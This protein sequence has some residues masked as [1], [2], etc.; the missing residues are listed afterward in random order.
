MEP[1]SGSFGLASVNIEQIDSNTFDVVSAGDPDEQRESNESQH[2]GTDRSDR[3][4][5]SFASRV[6]LTVVLENVETDGASGVDVATAERSK[7]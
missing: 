7:E 2:T 3:H 4:A 1:T 6:S 5:R